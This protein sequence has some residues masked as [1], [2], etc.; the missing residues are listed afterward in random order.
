MNEPK[1][2]PKVI[3]VTLNPSLDRT[4][5]TH[6]LALGYENRT[7]EATRLDPAGRGI[8]IARALHQLGVPTHALLLIGH[9]ATGRAYQALIAEEQFPISILRRDGLTRSGII[10][11]DSGHESETSIWEDSDGVTHDDLQQVAD[12]LI[13]LIHQGDKVVFAGSLPSGVS[14]DT[15]AWFADVVQSAGARVAINAGGGEAL[16]LALKAKP[17][18]VY[19]TQ[20]QVEHLFNFPVRAQE[21]VIHCAQKLR[22]EGAATVLI[23]MSQTNETIL[24][25]DNGILTA[26]WPD[27]ITGTHSGKA[28]AM[29]AGYLAGRFKELSRE[30][31]LSLSAASA[32]YTESQMGHEFGTLKD[33]QEHTEK[34]DVRST[35]EVD[36]TP[37]D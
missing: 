14:T 17:A 25:A 18:W 13:Q 23:A 24:V 22:D 32:I 5:P 19:L 9:D 34:V 26:S 12:T 20:L 16:Q 11:Q 28:E 27:E 6:F 2:Q 35:E 7:R 1:A 3:T 10:I 15:Y 21:D 29:I 8:G 37:E 4:V 31:A 33:M 36:Q 30:E